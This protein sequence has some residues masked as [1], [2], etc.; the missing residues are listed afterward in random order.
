M[1]AINLFTCTYCATNR[2]HS[3][4][5]FNILRPLQVRCIGSSRTPIT[6]ITVT[7]ILPTVAG[8]F[9]QYDLVF[10]PSDVTIPTYIAS[11]SHCNDTL[12]ALGG[13]HFSRTPRLTTRQPAYNSLH[14]MQQLVLSQL[15]PAFSL[16]RYHPLSY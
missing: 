16:Q 7:T 1:V 13:P 2:K 11:G 12:A 6:K 15:L 8:T 9:V 10:S 14:H 4:P 5:I 3:S